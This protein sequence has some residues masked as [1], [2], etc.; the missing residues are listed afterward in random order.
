MAEKVWGIPFLDSRK[1][2]VSY[3]NTV[4]DVVDKYRDEHVL[5]HNLGKSKLRIQQ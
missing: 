3:R 4:F 1:S 5:K 2:E